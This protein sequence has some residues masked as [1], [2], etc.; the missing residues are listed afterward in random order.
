MVRDCRAREDKYTHFTSNRECLRALLLHSTLH[1]SLE[2][3]HQ[4]VSRIN[5]LIMNMSLM[6]IT[7][8]I[9]P[10]GRMVLGP[11]CCDV[12]HAW[13]WNCWDRQR[14][15]N[16]WWTVNSTV[17]FLV[18]KQ[19]TIIS[20]TASAYLVAKQY[21]ARVRTFSLTYMS[22]VFMR[23]QIGCLVGGVAQYLWCGIPWNLLN[24]ILIFK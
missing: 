16:M 21:R 18:F 17:L 7:W 3:L 23:S 5:I 13:C 19:L 24:D 1:F 10:E 22:D 2:A 11:W 14:I 20:Y 4:W 8:S 9:E 6:N 12:P 15:S